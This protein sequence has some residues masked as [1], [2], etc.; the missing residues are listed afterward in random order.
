MAQFPQSEPDIAALATAMLV[1]YMNHPADFPSVDTASL[2]TAQNDY[3]S[4]KSAQIDAATA[5]QV[6]TDAKNTALDTLVGVMRTELKKSEVDVADD[7][8]KLGYIGWG[9]KAA[10]Q[11]DDPPGQ[12]RNLEA[13][14]QGTGTIFLD[15]K[16]PAR[17]TGGTVRMYLIEIRQQ[18][19]GGGEFGDWQQAGIAI[20]SETM[21][22]N[23]PRGPQLEYRVKAVGSGGQGPVS[24]TVA[25]VL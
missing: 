2:S 17:G 13:V 16:A 23:Q 3:A 21:L 11:P 22:I 25:A 10:A 18:P 1:G 24:N 5:A 19:A 15:W 7:D 14:I 4:A 6:A 9:A 20:E 8:E 12:V